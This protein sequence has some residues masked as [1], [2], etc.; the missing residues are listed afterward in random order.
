MRRY[1]E[2]VTFTV[3]TEVKAKLR[4]VAIKRGISLSAL[5]REITAAPNDVE[6]WVAR[7]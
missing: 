2:P 7:Q 6:Q 3:S 4:T 5:M 1:T